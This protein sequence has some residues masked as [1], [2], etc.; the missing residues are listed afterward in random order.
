MG[1]YSAARAVPDGIMRPRIAPEMSR[2]MVRVPYRSPVRLMKRNATRRASP[3]LLQACPIISAPI[4]SH[5]VL[6]VKPLN[7]TPGFASPAIIRN[8]SQSSVMMDASVTSAVS[9]MTQAMS[10]PKI[11]F[12]S[13][14]MPSMGRAI[15]NHV[16]AISAAATATLFMRL[17]IKP[18]QA[19][20]S[21]RTFR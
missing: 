13:G 10:A 7:A 21:C 9:R 14:V 8:T 12:P 19:P 17:F 6:S 1:T 11:L 20:G 4:S 3:V 2:H 5:V 18:D 15:Q 16:P